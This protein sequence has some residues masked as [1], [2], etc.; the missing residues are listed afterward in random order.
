MNKNLPDKW[1]RKA[2]FEAIDGIT[3]DGE[4]INCYDTRVTGP[5]DPD[6]FVLMTTQSN[7]VD[8]ANKC[9]YFWESQILLDVVTLYPLPGNPGSRLLA[10]N[11]LDAVRTNVQNLALDGASS[12]EII[13]QT[14]SYPNDLN[15]ATDNEVVY[16]K[17]LR[18]LLLIK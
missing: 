3:V 11:I 14:E 10:D 2:V 16:R 18:L 7:E 4:I 1:I 5:D 8:K 12:L 9:E 17:F 6:Y 15:L 13:R